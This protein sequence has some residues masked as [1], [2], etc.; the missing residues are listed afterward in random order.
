APVDASDAPSHFR[1]SSDPWN[2]R[3][4]GRP[5]PT[6]WPATRPMREKSRPC[7]LVVTFTRTVGRRP[8]SL[9]RPWSGVAPTIAAARAEGPPSRF[10]RA[11]R[12]ELAKHTAFDSAQA[13][14]SP[15]AGRAPTRYGVHVKLGRTPIDP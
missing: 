13:T 14:C 9:W 4:N 6:R 3:K 5:S 1:S 12:T 11:P 7:G 10:V 2:P 8:S 15:N